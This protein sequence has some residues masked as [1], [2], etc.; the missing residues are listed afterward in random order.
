MAIKSPTKRDS[1]GMKPSAGPATWFLL[2]AAAATLIWAYWGTVYGL[3]RD[4]Q[5]DPNYSVGQLVP[6]AALY[7]IWLDRRELSQT[8][9]R[10]DGLG[11]GL[12]IVAQLM[13]A[14]GLIWLFESA[15]RYALVLT[16]AAAVWIVAGRRMLLRLRW[17]LLFLFLMVPLPGK[18]HVMISGP[19]QDYATNGAVFGLELLGIVVIQQGH[20]ILLN[21]E[22]PINIAEE[23]SGLRMLTAFIVVAAVFAFMVHRSKAQ[24]VFLILSSIPIAILCNVIRLVVTALLFLYLNSDLAERFFHDFAGLTMMPIAVLL[25]AAELWLLSKLILPDPPEVM[26]QPREAAG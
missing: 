17:I 3:Y 1:T 24:K 13:R 6:L 12:L 20:R 16:I 23:C 26:A 2:A 22:V 15:E 18:I 10:F 4:W 19:L 7:L 5:T 25:L 9:M 8:P 11:I 21:D 14:F